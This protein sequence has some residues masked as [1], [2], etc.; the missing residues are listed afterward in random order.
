MANLLGDLWQNGEPRWDRALAVPGV[1]L[2]LY[3]K[4]KSKPKR[5]MGHLTATGSTAQEAKQ[6]VLAARAAL[7]IAQESEI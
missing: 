4:T 5:K 6:R 1:H 2:H 7:T 3:G